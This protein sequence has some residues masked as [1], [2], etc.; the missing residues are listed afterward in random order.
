AAGNYHLKLNV[1]RRDEIGR[2]ANN[3][4]IM[5]NSLEKTEEKR[6]EFVSG[7]SH[8]IKSPLASIQGFAQTLRNENLS[9]QERIHYLTI[10]KKESKRLSALI[11]NLLTIPILYSEM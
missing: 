4:S 10:I 8:E 7:V 1:Y 6:Q 11:K 3:F 5:S 2:L 9:K